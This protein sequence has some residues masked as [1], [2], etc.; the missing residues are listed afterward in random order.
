MNFYDRI[1]PFTGLIF[2]P[3]ISSSCFKEEC[4]PII[5]SEPTDEKGKNDAARHREKHREAIKRNLP[6]IIGDQPIITRKEGKIVKIPIRYLDLPHFKPKKG[7][8]GRIGQGPGEPGDII[9]SRPGS[10]QPGAPG[11]EPGVDYLEAE[12]PIEEL[13]EMMFEDL[14][15]PNLQQKDLRDLETVLGIKISGYTS[16]APP[17][18]RSAPETARAGIKRFWGFL[19]ALKQQTGLDE[20]TCYNALK[21]AG[22]LF[23]KALEVIKAGAVQISEDKVEP[24]PIIFPDD[25][26]YFDYHEDIQRDSRAVIILIMDVSGSMTDDKK[27]IAHALAFWIVEALRKVYKTVETRFIV[28]HASA[29]L[30]EEE[31]FF[32]VVE[33][34]G[35][36]CAKGYE[37][38]NDLIET[39]YQ[40]S[41]WNVYALHFS[42]GEDWDAQLTVN[43]VSKLFA[44]NINLLGYTEIQPKREIEVIGG[45]LLK[46][47]RKYFPIYDLP[48]RDGA[49]NFCVGAGNLPFIGAEISHKSHV[50]PVVCEFL[51]KDRRWANG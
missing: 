48:R 50:Y 31:E 42:D 28:H 51:K 35:T 8:R 2:I 12:Y 33:S 30:V 16:E 32:R 21:Q 15:L 45:E 34:G 39:Q 20:L 17:V 24:F 13:I 36:I 22:G 38:A 10:G 47:F 23:D 18:L 40:T 19:E 37:L 4:M 46:A 3:R 49:P 27:Y 41:Q 44:K 26:R 1:S 25:Y 6:K 11:Q 9:H 29:R 14:G 5:W 7:D 43:E